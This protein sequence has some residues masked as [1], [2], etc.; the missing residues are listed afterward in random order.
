MPRLTRR[1]S[2]VAAAGGIVGPTAFVAAWALLGSRTAGYSPV[3]DPISGLAASG[4]PTQAT[5]TAGLLA[6]GTGLPVSAIALR[7]ALPGPA[8]VLAASS[9]L[10]TLGLAAFPLGSPNGDGAHGAFAAVGYATLAALPLAATG[11]LAGQGRRHWAAFSLITGAVSAACLLATVSSA[12]PG[13]FQRAG[14][15]VA[16]LWVVATAAD[17]LRNGSR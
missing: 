10:A 17:V 4:A 13:L 12:A 3:H 16:H 5:M 15:T 8:W 9:G 14:L 2:R 7:S 11:P 1:A 6:L